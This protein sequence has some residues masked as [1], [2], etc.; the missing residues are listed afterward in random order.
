MYFRKKTSGGRA[1]L[2]IVESRREGAQVRQQV[3]ATLGRIEDLHASGQLERLLRSGAR[4]AAKAIVVDAVNDGTAISADVRRIGPALVFE[5]LWEETG[6]R[7]VIE[8][9]AGERKHGF[10][11][12]RAIFLTVLHRLFT[13]GSDRAADR[14]REDYRIDGVEGL[15]LHHLYRAMAW[16][17]EELPAAEQDGCTLAPRCLK[18]IV[19]ERLFERRRDLFTK[20]DLVFMDTTSLYFEGAGGQTLGRHGYS[21]D[22][23]PDLRQMILAVLLDGDGRPV[24]TEMW[25]GNTADTGSLVPVVDRL[26]QRFSIGRVCIVADRGMISAETI[27][28]LEARGLLYLLGVRERTDKLVRELVL[29]DPGP[30]VPLAITKRGKS[31]DYEAKAVALAGR[32]YIV[33]R[34]HAEAKKD[35]ADRAAI[36]AAL[37]QQL[38]K[39]D[40]ALVGNG[41]YRRFLATTGQN[42]FVIDRAKAEEDARFDGIFVLRTNTDIAPLD[43]MLCYKQLTMVEQAFRTTK[44]LFETRPIFHKLDETIRG[45]V[46]CSFLALVLKKA[47][48]DRIA[49]LGKPGSWPEILADLD[50]LTE[51]EVGQDGK[52]FMLR[53]APRPAASLA[54][55]AV[56]VALPPTV[57]QV[58]ET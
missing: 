8:Q 39:G 27:A 14:W 54:L 53:S 1:Y 25:P 5:R 23:R 20:L 24:C 3:I 50:S 45:H 7:S 42:G 47:L 57:R 16:L 58:A 32:R 36:L 26:R 30:F 2:Q 34:N 35:A 29:D 44:S 55:R 52:R 6:C 11:L 51:T 49:D 15:E 18:D 21:K 48:E 28:E 9:L 33:C 56:G 46:S 22:H 38:K 31:V 13:G 4:F 17:G 40:K 19:E 43:A 12:E 10:A 41:G 37:E